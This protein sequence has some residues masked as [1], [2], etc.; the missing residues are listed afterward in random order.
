MRYF[1]HILVDGVLVR[2]LE[3][4]DLPSDEAARAEAYACALEL[5]REFPR[6][7]DIAPGNVVEL[8]DEIGRALLIVPIYP[9][10]GVARE[11]QETGSASMGNSGQLDAE[12]H[13]SGDT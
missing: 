12:V 10:S 9:R 2:D 3:G 1:F 4:T 8:A 13:C 5:E 6:K 11:Q 7:G